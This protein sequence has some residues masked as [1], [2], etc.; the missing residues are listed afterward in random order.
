MCQRSMLITSNVVVYIFDVCMLIVP[1]SDLEI[2][3]SSN[4][5]GEL[6]TVTIECNVTAN[7]PANINWLKR[8]SEKRRNHVNTSRTSITHQVTFTSRGPVTGSTLVISNVEA[9]DSGDYICEAR[10]SHSSPPV[11][12]N[13]SIIVICKSISHRPTYRSNIKHTE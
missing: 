12:T 2:R 5:P 8:T 13:F 1:P 10:N 4:T 7:P 11:S 3:G 9:A 6:D